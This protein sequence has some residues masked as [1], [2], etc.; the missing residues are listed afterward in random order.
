L[1]LVDT[2]VWIDFLI[3]AESIHRA[4]LHRL[5]EAEE[6]LCLADIVL[7]EILSGIRGD[8]EFG[9]LRDRLFEF[10]IYS[11]SDAESYVAAAELYRRCRKKG[12]TLR[13]ITDCLISCIAIE[14]GLLLFHKDKDFDRIARIEKDLRILD[15]VSSS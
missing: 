14:N 1:I 2:S 9:K 3:G 10:P 4:A 6:D 5:I 8:R 12:V 15:V 11:L 13:G 7:C